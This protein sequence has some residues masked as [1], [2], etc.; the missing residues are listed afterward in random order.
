LIHLVNRASIAASPEIALMDLSRVGIP[1]EPIPPDENVPTSLELLDPLRDEVQAEFLQDLSA[2]VK[3]GIE[4]LRSLLR[5]TEEVHMNL[6]LRGVEGRCEAMLDRR[7]RSGIDPGQRKGKVLRFNS[8]VG[9]VRVV[10]VQGCDRDQAGWS[11]DRVDNNYIFIASIADS[12][13]VANDGISIVDVRQTR[14]I[15]LDRIEMMLA[16]TPQVTEIWTT[17]GDSYLIHSTAAPHGLTQLAVIFAPKLDFPWNSNF[18][19]ILWLNRAAGRSFQ[20]PN[21]YPVFP[22]VVALLDDRRVSQIAQFNEPKP[23]SSVA[24]VQDEISGSMC[25]SAE[26][27]SAPELITGGLPDWASSPCEFV[28]VMRQTLESSRIGELLPTWIEAV[29]G[30]K[31]PSSVNHGQLFSGG[32]R[33]KCAI[34]S[35]NAKWS[36]FDLDDGRIVFSAVDNNKLIIVNRSHMVSE[37]KIDAESVSTIARSQMQPTTASDFWYCSGLLS[38]YDRTNGTLTQFGQS[39]GF[40]ITISGRLFVDMTNRFIYSPDQFDIWSIRITGEKKLRLRSRSR[41]IA[42]AGSQPFRS[43]VFTTIDRK[44][45]FA[46]LVKESEMITIDVPELIDAIVITPKWGFVVMHSKSTLFVYNVNGTFVK[47]STLSSEILTWTTFSSF[48]GFDYVAFANEAG[49]VNYFEVYYP[50][51]LENLWK[52]RDVIMISY[53]L[54]NAWFMIVT[55]YGKV[56]VKPV[57]IRPNSAGLSIPD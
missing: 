51:L 4:A 26:F 57:V 37:W 34:P 23:A 40:E 15:S 50:D 17:G 2:T 22:S 12:G 44:V 20:D 41:I 7:A 24:D 53:E 1:D 35:K 6:D 27:Y 46:S 18:G 56:L 39:K 36:E 3:D 38:A 49:E 14:A 16:R 21:C 32:F 5:Q 28:Y 29:F 30:A 10:P 9:L 13:E 48:A 47:S 42:M 52:C 11:L 19:Y 43:L 54:D 55:K 33:H 45:H 25:I 8:N 31:K